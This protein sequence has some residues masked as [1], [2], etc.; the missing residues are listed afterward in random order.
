[1]KRRRVNGRQVELKKGRLFVDG[2]YRF[3]KIGKPLRDFSDEGQ[4]NDLI[5]DLDVIQEKKF[6]CLEINCY[7]HHMDRD[8]DGVVDVELE[9]LNRLIDAI[10]ERGMFV[11]LSV[12][13]YGVGGGQVPEGYWDKYPDTIAVAV[14]GSPVSDVEF[15]YM[16]KVPSLYSEDYLRISR[17]FISD[18]ASK[19]DM[20]KILYFETTVEPQYMGGLSIDYS[21]ESRRAYE[22][23]VGENRPDARPFPDHFPIPQEFVY[24]PVWNQF[25]AEWLAEWVSGDA[26][27]YRAVAGE[28]A[29]VACE[30]LDAAEATMV[31]RCGDPITF[32]RGLKT[33]DIIQVNW[34]WHYGNRAPNLKAYQ[35]VKAA[36]ELCGAE[37]VITEHMTIN[38]TDY[39]P[40]EIHALLLNTIRNGSQFGWE[41]VD[42]AADRDDSSVPEGQVVPG[43]FKPAHF[44]LYDKDWKPKPAMAVVDE[45]WDYWMD[46]I[47]R[48]TGL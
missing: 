39:R 4:V 27:A 35:R 17:A 19:L 8:G 5:A 13:T 32:L 31:N 44:A 36:M 48:E 10:C 9:P 6:N 3:L 30:Y 7:W 16:S 33:V 34:H 29:W 42:V 38:G 11:S 18:L 28:D 47:R 2:T 40:E 15:G 41:F 21:A 25:R 43:N 46:M 26:A 23:W 45:R 24:D 1:M 37:W 22:K 20:S 12:E 14:D